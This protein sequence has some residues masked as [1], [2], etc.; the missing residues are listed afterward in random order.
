[1]T[2]TEQATVQ[3]AVPSK[4]VLFVQSLARSLVVAVVARYF[5]DLAQNPSVSL[6]IDFGVAF[7]VSLVMAW[8]STKATV[9]HAMNAAIT[10]LETQGTPEPQSASR[11]GPVDTTEKPGA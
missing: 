6:A 5:P 1:M 9:A 8:I 11:I 10:V 4:V 3:Q 2:Q 7:G